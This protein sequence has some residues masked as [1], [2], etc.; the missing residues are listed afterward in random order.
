MYSYN[1]FQWMP[2]WLVMCTTKWEFES[3]KFH[4]LVLGAMSRAN[5][6]EVFSSKKWA[7]KPWDGYFVRL[8]A[9][10]FMTFRDNLDSYS[11]LQWLFTSH[12]FEWMEIPTT[13]T[14]GVSCRCLLGQPKL[15][16]DCRW[17]I[18][19]RSGERGWGGGKHWTT[20][21]GLNCAIMR[22]ISL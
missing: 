16:W 6:S 22:D 8:K 15:R 20:R 5:S 1:Y 17:G 4:G 18:S 13:T 12:H 14:T 19:P 10:M 7:S 2:R 11:I 9:F 21:N 3:N